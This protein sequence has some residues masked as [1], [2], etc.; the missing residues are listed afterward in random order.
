MP[1]TPTRNVARPRWRSRWNWWTRPPPR[2][3]RRPLPDNRD[4]VA[5][6]DD[7]T[8]VD[9]ELLDHSVGLRDDRDLHLHRIEDDRRVALGHLAPLVGDH[10]PHVGHHLG[11]DLLGH[12]PSPSTLASPCDQYPTTD[13]RGRRR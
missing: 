10:L 5:L 2:R 4:Q 3:T 9:R 7:V 13:R 11:A 8:L 1:T 12:S 6:L